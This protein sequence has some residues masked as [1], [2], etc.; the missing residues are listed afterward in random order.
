MPP[1]ITRLFSQ[2]TPTA[3]GVWAIFGLIAIWWIRGIPERRRA[4]DD[5]EGSLRRDLLKRIDALEAQQAQDRHEHAEQRE[6]DR[7][8][9]QDELN[10][11]RHESNEQRRESNELRQQIREQEKLIDGLQRQLILYQIAAGRA[12]PPSAEIDDMIKA[13]GPI[14]EK[15]FPFNPPATK[16]ET[17]T[18]LVQTTRVVDE[19]EAKK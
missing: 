13:L 10:E 15:G 18:E 17:T 16:T 8:A 1:E 2:F 3:Y 7:K 14:L 19:G 4:K 12:V 9:C 6:A 11:L 5:G